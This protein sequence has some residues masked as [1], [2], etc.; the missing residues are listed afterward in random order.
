MDLQKF[1]VKNIQLVSVNWF[2]LINENKIYHI[3]N[4]KSRLLIVIVLMPHSTKYN[5]G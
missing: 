3:D 2:I 1:Y 5:Q 4:H